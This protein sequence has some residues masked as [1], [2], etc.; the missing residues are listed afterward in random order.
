MTHAMTLPRPTRSPRRSP[1]P[2]V[3]RSTLRFLTRGETPSVRAV[4]LQLHFGM[5]TALREGDGSI[6]AT[7]K[8]IAAWAGVSYASVKRAAARLRDLAWV[9]EL[10]GGRIVFD[11]RRSAPVEKAQIEPSPY[12]EVE[13]LREGMNHHPIVTASTPGPELPPSGEDGLG[14]PSVRDREVGSSNQWSELAAHN[15]LVPD[16]NQPGERCNRTVEV[17][18]ERLIRNQQVHQATPHR[19]AKPSQMGACI[20][21]L[22]EAGADRPGAVKAAQSARK[23]GALSLEIVQRITAAVQALPTR[24]FKPAA[25]ICAAVARPELGAKL[26][27]DH[28]RVTRRKVTS[29]PSCGAQDATRSTNPAHQVQEVGDEV[30]PWEVM[31]RTVRGWLEILDVSEAE[32]RALI[33]DQA[34]RHGWILAELRTIP[35]LRN[36]QL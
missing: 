33:C 26:L 22:V 23:A 31:R 4:A 18:A 7:W 21:A 10:P 13:T 6:H 27:R 34:K 19:A 14:E 24:P 17:P 28:A 5:V 36:V 16:S 32:D 30:S 11:Y 3:K 2:F 9:K 15:R 12:I 1:D 35:E 20:A 25:L 29:S 8:E